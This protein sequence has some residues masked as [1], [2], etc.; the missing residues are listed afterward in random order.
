MTDAL[1]YQVAVQS[2][3]R[4]LFDYLPPDNASSTLA[5]GVRV[6]VP[7]GKRE[8]TGIIVSSTPDSDYPASKLKPI[9]AVLDEAP[10]IP[11]ILF[12]VLL[13][14]ARYYQHPVGDV[15]ASAL[16]TV[17]R[18]G[19]ELP[20][21]QFY[22]LSTHGKGLPNDALSRAPKQQTLLQL[23]QQHESLSREA[24][25]AAGVST[26]TLRSLL[27]KELIESFTTTA[28]NPV[29]DINGELDLLA[30]PALSL[31]NDQQA[32]LQQVEFH[33]YNSYLIDGE[34]GSGKTE[35]YLQA[36]A[37]VLRYSRQADS[38]N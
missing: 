18:K 11:P 29:F 13:W 8:V 36:I 15:L 24:L 12:D 21:Q 23:L 20:Q 34:T 28:S 33:T 9:T 3:L 7:F 16:P 14:A 38:R 10:L 5:P 30:E 35:V 37:T 32:A 25:T 6:T 27:K 4:R 2:P 22:R 31:S 17:L 26:A 19:G 1:F